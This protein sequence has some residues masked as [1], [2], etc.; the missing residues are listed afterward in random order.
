MIKDADQNVIFIFVKRYYSCVTVMISNF[1][2]R[3]QCNQY[4]TNWEFILSLLINYIARCSQAFCILNSI[5]LTLT[6]DAG[7]FWFHD[8]V[9]WCYYR[10]YLCWVA[11]MQSK[12]NLTSISVQTKLISIWHISIQSKVMIL[13]FHWPDIC[14]MRLVLVWA[15]MA[16]KWSSDCAVAIHH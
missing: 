5:D 4:V 7:L 10:V 8:K 16:V 11:P 3:F 15:L 6:T 9:L 12:L 2:C 14:Q 13:S 1:N